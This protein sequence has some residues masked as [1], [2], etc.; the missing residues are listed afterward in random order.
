MELLEKVKA[1]EPTLEPAVREI[2][3]LLRMLCEQQQETIKRQEAIINELRAENAQLKQMLFGRKSEALKEGRL[4]SIDKE[5]R[6]IVEMEEIFGIEPGEDEKAVLDGKAGGGQQQLGLNEVDRRK[7]GRS[8]SE[9][10]RAKHRLARK[11]LKVVTETVLVTPDKL[12]EGYTLEDFRQVGAGEVVRRLEHVREHVVLVEYVLQTLASRDG[13]HLLKAP[14]PPAVVEGGHYGPGVYAHIVTAKCDDSLPLY[15]I[16]KGFERDGCHI[17]RSTL[18]ELFHRAAELFHPIADLLVEIASMDRYLHMDETPQP[19]LEEGGC[20]RGW[21]WTLVSPQV[22][23]YKFSATRASQTPEKLLTG[24]QGFLH[25]DAY[26]G[27][28]SSGKNGRIPVRCWGH[29]RRNFFQALP[30]ANEE[31]SEMLAMIIELYRVEYLAA[32]QDIQGTESH[33]LLRKTKS[34]AITDRIWKWLQEKQPVHPPKSPLGKAISYAINNWK[35]LTEFQNDPKILLDNNLAE[36]ALRIFALGRKNFLFVGH[37][38]AGENL[39]VLQT[40]VSTCRL[41][42]VNVYDYIKDVLIRVQTHPASRI[43]EL[44]PFNWKPPQPAQT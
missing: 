36:N 7:R 42:G 5:V 23:G 12:P 43:E 26:A 29:N 27:Y 22:V 1:L 31:A 8:R 19:V 6:R 10:K 39:A 9:K 38:Q 24:T 33:L 30:T 20:R 15:R 13:K 18:C 32:E 28:N 40:I 41:H 44:L 37:D 21:I 14:S 35:A 17:A 2:V 4:P 11:Q 16:E 3:T 25:T 34:K